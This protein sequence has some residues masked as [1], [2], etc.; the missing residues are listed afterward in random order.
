M[1]ILIA[2]HEESEIQARCRDP[3]EMNIL[4]ADHEESDVHTRSPS[5]GS[6][7][8]PS[9]LMEAI[10]AGRE[11]EE[12]RQSVIVDMLEQMPF[13]GTLAFSRRDE[14]ANIL[15]L[16]THER[17]AVIYREGDFGGRFYIVQGGMVE[18]RKF[19]GRESDGRARFRRI[20]EIDNH[21]DRPWFGE[22]GLWLS[23]GRQGTA[24]VRSESVRLLFLSPA[25][26]DTFLDIVP[27]F[28]L[29]N[30]KSHAQVQ[31]DRDRDS[32]GDVTRKQGVLD[33]TRTV[34][35]VGVA[36]QWK[37]GAVLGGLGQDSMYSER[38]LYAERW[39]RIVSQLLFE[40]C[41]GYATQQATVSL[42]TE[43]YS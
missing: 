14:L 9:S 20:A 37:S 1:N 4:I 13:F 7:G 6:Q 21:G 11:W 23:K 22:V 12:L 42:K 28:R 38:S 34:T 17:G 10:A 5:K 31:W 29:Y 40:V 3:S 35:Q 24:I 41:G 18:L 27:D 8:S 15:E 26:F 39:E 36:L 2:D 30:N 19:E 33:E 25:N 32:A 16:E 43:D